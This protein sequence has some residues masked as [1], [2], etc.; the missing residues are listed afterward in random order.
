MV[1]RRASREPLEKGGWSVFLTAF[2][3][4]E[5]AD[6]SGNFPLR[7]NG[8]GAWFGWP[9]IPRLEELRDA[10]FD[11]PDLDSQKKLAREIQLTMLDE[12]PYIP[13]GAYTSMTSFRRNLTGRVPGFALFWNIRR[14]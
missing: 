13:V 8:A 11:A 7:G 14:G 10:W 3:S 4:F 2:A 9:T 6:P 12:V 1:Q 5:F